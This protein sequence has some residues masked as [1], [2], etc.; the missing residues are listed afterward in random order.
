MAYYTGIVASLRSV[1]ICVVDDRGEV[2]REAKLDAQVPVIADWLRKRAGD[3]P[4]DDEM[5]K[6]YGVLKFFSYEASSKT[7]NVRELKLQKK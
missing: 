6:P 4:R 1:S 5:L 2:C 7:T 3:N